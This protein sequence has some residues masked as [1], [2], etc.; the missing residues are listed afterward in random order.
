MNIPHTRQIS[1]IPAWFPDVFCKIHVENSAKSTPEP[2]ALAA[3]RV[4]SISGTP[5]AHCPFPLRQLP[6]CRKPSQIRRCGLA[7]FLAN[8][9]SGMSIAHYES[10]IAA[11][12]IT[13]PAPLT[14]P[15]HLRGSATAH[16]SLGPELNFAVRSGGPPIGLRSGGPSELQPGPSGPG[17]RHIQSQSP[18]R[19][20]RN[21]A[22]T[23][24]DSTRFRAVGF[25]RSGI[26]I[27]PQTHRLVPEPAGQWVACIC[28]A[29]AH[30]LRPALSGPAT[31]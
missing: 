9:I 2:Q 10:T 20:D 30:L 4:N 22:A 17:T 14:R 29:L 7:A 21:R 11:A 28:S 15:A 8:S 31:F 27:G 13:L 26:S 3:F 1:I 25:A 23:R 18:G 5:I 24:C 19:G 16:G 12:G 6:L